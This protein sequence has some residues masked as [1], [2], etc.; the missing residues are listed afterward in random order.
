MWHLRK[1]IFFY[2]QSRMLMD[3]EDNLSTETRKFTIL[4]KF[5]DYDKPTSTTSLT[6]II[7]RRSIRRVQGKSARKK[8]ITAILSW[9]LWKKAI[10]P[11][12][13][14]YQIK[15]YIYT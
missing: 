14:R 5:V 4:I 8:Q 7:R 11:E 1:F 13:Q 9:N 10:P 15:V 2:T 3:N 6:T 12:Y